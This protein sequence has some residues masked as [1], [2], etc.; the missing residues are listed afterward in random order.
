MNKERLE[1]KKAAAESRWEAAQMQAA[2]AQ[3]ELD[4]AISVFEKHKDEL[5]TTEQQSTVVKIDE[6]RNLI[7]DFLLKSH[8]VYQNAVLRYAAETKGHNA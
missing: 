3:R 1:Q 5:S 2:N 4:Y 8:Q 7:K 6:Q